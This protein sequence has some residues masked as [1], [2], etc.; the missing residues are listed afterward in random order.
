TLALGIGAN[1]AIFSVVNTVL[2]RP[3]KTPDADRLVR[4]VINFGTN[5]SFVASGREF[6]A[7]RRTSAFEDVSAHRLEFVNMTGDAQAEEIP[8]GRVSANFFSLF[9]APVLQGRVF[10]NDEDRP[11]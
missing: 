3:L 7:W 1:A 10:T 4:F 5:L 8:V 6:D 9:H 2:L 11:K